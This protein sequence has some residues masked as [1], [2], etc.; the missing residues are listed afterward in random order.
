MIKRL[1]AAPETRRGRITLVAIF[2]F[3]AM[4]VDLVLTRHG[5]A[6]SQDS[7]VY[8]SVAENWARHGTLNQYDGSALVQFPPGFSLLL[9]MMLRSGFSLFGAG[10]VLEAGSL[11]VFVMAGTWLGWR[12]LGKFWWALGIVA[13]LVSTPLVGQDYAYLWSEAVF[14][15]ASAVSLLAMVML[16]QRQRWSWWLAG[17][18]VGSLW[19]CE[20][21]RYMGIDLLAVVLV[22]AL[23]VPGGAW[24]R[25]VRAV[26]LTFVSALA[27]I[28]VAGR[29]L[30]LGTGVLGPRLPTPTTAKELPGQILHLVGAQM[31]GDILGTSRLATW[32]NSGAVTL[33]MGGLGVSLVLWAVLKALR[34]RNYAV[35]LLGTFVIVVWVSLIYSALTA[36]IFAFNNRLTSPSLLAAAL[37]VVYAVTSGATPL[38][39]RRWHWRKI[40][41]VGATVLLVTSLSGEIFSG[42][43]SAGS[44]ASTLGDYEQALSALGRSG[45]VAAPHGVGGYLSLASGRTVYEIYVHDYYCP[46]VCVA[47]QDRY[48]E[49]V[50]A[51]GGL[52]YALWGQ[53]MPGGLRRRLLKYDVVTHYL[54]TTP[55]GVAVYRL[56]LRR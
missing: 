46:L 48:L 29:N 3:V 17:V 50:L 23:M 37:C 16:V 7:T 24:V 51:R 10:W 47:R 45:P 8:A 26:G 14:M 52:H 13:V 30:L 53:G 25:L 11:G 20:S 42:G 2:A 9:G 1:K 56:T 27:A 21:V 22:G 55:L 18:A 44:G 35:V 5:L 32:L 36:A 31:Q 6:Y 41:G 40:V 49:G 54:G 19:V 28:V 4:A 34:A 43:I 39:R 15:A 38:Q 33:V 12:V